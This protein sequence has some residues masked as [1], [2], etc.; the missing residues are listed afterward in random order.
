MAAHLE[1]QTDAGLRTIGIEVLARCTESGEA[2]D[3][4]AYGRAVIAQD[5][6]VAR[7]WLGKAAAMGHPGAREALTETGLGGRWA[8]FRAR[9]QKRGT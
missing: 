5:P 4:F 2:E 8:L 9:L 6:V 3:L 1:R 7:K